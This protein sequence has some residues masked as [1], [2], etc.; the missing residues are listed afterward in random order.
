[1]ELPKNTVVELPYTT[2]GANY[3]TTADDIPEDVGTVTYA[4]TKY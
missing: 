2:S 3:I 4:S 1:L